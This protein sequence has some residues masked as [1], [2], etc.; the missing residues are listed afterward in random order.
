VPQEER[1]EG[2]SLEERD[3]NV[4]AGVDVQGLLGR[5]DCVEQRKAGVLADQLVVPLKDKQYRDRESA[6][7]FFEALGPGPVPESRQP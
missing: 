4:T 3:L 2:V 1:L 5:A 7:S 6:R